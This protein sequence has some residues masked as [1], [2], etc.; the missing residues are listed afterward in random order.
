MHAATSGSGDWRRRARRWLIDVHN[1]VNKHLKKRVL[2]VQEA[3]A[4]IKRF[5]GVRYES[6]FVVTTVRTNL[7][8][9]RPKSRAKQEARLDK[10]EDMLKSRGF[11]VAAPHKTRR[12]ANRLVIT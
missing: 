2:T 10:L 7:R 12:R 11:I 6:P 5:R 9:N 8:R 1:A 3:R 4:A